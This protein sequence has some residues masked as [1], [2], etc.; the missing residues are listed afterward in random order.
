VTRANVARQARILRNTLLWAQLEMVWF[1]VF[2]LNGWGRIDYL[3]EALVA[4]LAIT[5]G[6]DLVSARRAR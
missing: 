4:A 5:M 6:V 3:V 1:M 2:L